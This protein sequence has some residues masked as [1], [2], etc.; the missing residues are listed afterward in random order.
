MPDTALLKAYTRGLKFHQ[1]ECPRLGVIARTPELWRLY[2][3]D[4][5]Y[6]AYQ[7]PLICVGTLQ[8]PPSPASLPRIST[9]TLPQYRASSCVNGNYRRVRTN[10]R[11]LKLAVWHTNGVSKWTQFKFRT[12]GLGRGPAHHLRCG[13][14]A[15]MKVDLLRP[16]SCLLVQ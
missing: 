12:T 2:Q 6:Q 11:I 5:N 15:I 16:N 1:A 10:A 8:S 13:K 4:E 7:R 14:R 9:G 3:L